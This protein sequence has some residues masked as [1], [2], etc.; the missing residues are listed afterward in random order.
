MKTITIEV[1]DGDLIKSK[2]FSQLD[3]CSFEWGDSER[4]W[5]EMWGLINDID[6]EKLEIDRS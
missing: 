1:E 4:L 2:S 3:I 5:K 6:F